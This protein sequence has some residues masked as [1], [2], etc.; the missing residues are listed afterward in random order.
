M[1]K[2][3][4]I[5]AKLLWLS[6]EK[7]GISNMWKFSSIGVA[8]RLPVKKVA[9]NAFKLGKNISILIYS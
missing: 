9:T 3:A 5:P 1:H 8:K 7:G 6:T 2:N 4:E